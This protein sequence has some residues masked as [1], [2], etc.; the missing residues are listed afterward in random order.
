MMG[1]KQATKAKRRSDKGPRNQ[2]AR[3]KQAASKQQQCELADKAPPAGAQ[4]RRPR[5]RPRAP[6]APRSRNELRCYWALGVCGLPPVVLGRW[7]G[8]TRSP[9]C[10]N[11]SAPTYT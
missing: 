8:A 5:P 6:G 9:Q 10:S 2:E 1:R 7:M 3:S 4:V 11:G